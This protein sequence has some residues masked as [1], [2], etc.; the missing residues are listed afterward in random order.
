MTFSHKSL[1]NPSR[2]R[3]LLYATILLAFQLSLSGCVLSGEE[4][5]NDL[6]AG[7]NAVNAAYSPA[8]GYYQQQQLQQQQQNFERQ[9]QQMLIM[10]MQ[11]MQRTQ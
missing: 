8:P 7:G 3:C 9:H 2:I 10:Q 1:H 5:M 11:Q 6:A 4:M